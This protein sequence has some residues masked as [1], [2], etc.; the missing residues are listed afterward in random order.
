MEH[1]PTPWHIECK[2]TDIWDKLGNLIA[3][4]PAPFGSTEM[5][6]KAVANT[7][8]ITLACNAHDDLLA[9]CEEIAKKE[10]AFN[11][12]PLQH[13]VNCIDHMA[14]TAAAAI[15]KAK[16]NDDKEP[17][18]LYATVRGAYN[19]ET[20]EE[21]LHIES[22]MSDGQKGAFAVVDAE[23]PKMAQLFAA[24]PDLL[25]ACEAIANQFETTSTPDVV[26][27][28]W[29]AVQRAR[30]AIAKAKGE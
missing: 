25:A 7:A 30:A 28:A 17:S 3:H 9:A 6:D 14:E 15:A 10:G 1:T 11:R 29:V 23:F 8:F 2:P 20:D 24:C 5:W 18:L 27:I 22:R 13:A 26:E 16:G 12:D 4:I 19:P 21:E